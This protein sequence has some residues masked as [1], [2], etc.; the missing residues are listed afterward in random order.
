M[1]FYFIMFFTLLFT[2]IILVMQSTDSVILNHILDWNKTSSYMLSHFFFWLHDRFFFFFSAH[3][4]S[5]NSCVKNTIA[6]RTKHAYFTPCWVRQSTASRTNPKGV[7]SYSK[8]HDGSLPPSFS[9]PSPFLL[10]LPTI[11]LP[12]CMRNRL[13][14]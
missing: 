9:V 13:G 3:A 8:S 7:F 1:L 4:S 11:A 14:K 6:A 12:Q 2:I 10:L 5:L